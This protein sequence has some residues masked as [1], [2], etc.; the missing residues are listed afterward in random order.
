MECVFTIIVRCHVTRSHGFWIG[1]AA[2]YSD[3]RVLR[4][5][6]LSL[7]VWNFYIF[8]DVRKVGIT[9]LCIT[10]LYRYKEQEGVNM[11]NH[12]IHHNIE[13]RNKA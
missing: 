11:S 6:V 10:L 3:W 1:H 13:Q 5:L 9:L 8:Y 7:A 2:I 4:Q 12:S